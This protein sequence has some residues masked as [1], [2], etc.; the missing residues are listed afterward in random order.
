MLKKVSNRFINV[1]F[2]EI[3]DGL[4]AFKKSQN[5]K[6]EKFYI[7]ATMDELMIRFVYNMHRK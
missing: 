6:M 7:P 4:L 2:I 5:L 1:D 3:N